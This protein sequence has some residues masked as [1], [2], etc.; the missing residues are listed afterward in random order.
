VQAEDEGGEAVG[1]PHGEDAE[2]A[3]AGEREPHQRD[4]VEGV[5]ELADDDRGVGAAEVAPVQQ[6][7][8]ARRRQRRVEFLLRQRGDG[9][10]HDDGD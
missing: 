5:A 6:V 7:E 8:R 10:C 3:G 4:V 1:E 9:I 2:R